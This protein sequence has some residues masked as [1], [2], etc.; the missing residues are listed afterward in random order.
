M[1]KKHI[2]LFI[3][4]FFSKQNILVDSVNTVERFLTHQE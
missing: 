1:K 4:F 3:D 2:H